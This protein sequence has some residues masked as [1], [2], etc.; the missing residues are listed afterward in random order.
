M[1]GQVSSI[2]KRNLNRA[3]IIAKKF[4]D[5]ELHK[6]Q[7]CSRRCF[8]IAASEDL[9]RDS[10]R[11]VEYDRTRR[12]RYLV[13]LYEPV[14]E[15]YAYR[16]SAVCYQFLTQVFGFSRE[17]QWSN[18]KP[19]KK[20]AQLAIEKKRGESVNVVSAVCDSA[21]HLRTI[22]YACRQTK[23]INPRRKIRTLTRSVHRNLIWTNI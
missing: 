12:Q 17:M 11:V 20:A 10:F 6:V 4:E 1:K 22:E 14:S 19:L 15:M 16:G 13:S 5:G 18:K 23:R 7:C 2:R 21:L 3:K 8:E 9:V